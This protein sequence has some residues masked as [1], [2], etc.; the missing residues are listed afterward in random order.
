MSEAQQ[1]RAQ[2]R[3]FERQAAEA[4]RSEAREDFLRLAQL[5]NQLAEEGEGAEPRNAGGARPAR[6]S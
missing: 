5:W 6:A 4:R 3:S 1:Y 2:A